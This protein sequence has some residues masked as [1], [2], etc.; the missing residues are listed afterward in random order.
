MT[1]NA[2]HIYLKVR[3]A[4]LL[5]IN[6]QSTGGKMIKEE[7]AITRHASHP[8]H[9]QPKCKARPPHH[10]AHPH[11][12]KITFT[13]KLGTTSIPLSSAKKM[14]SVTGNRTP[15]TSALASESDVS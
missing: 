8:T 13:V 4:S 9:T 7:A 10:V 14:F 6:R 11:H 5:D 2:V 15:A 3:I 1:G 12:E